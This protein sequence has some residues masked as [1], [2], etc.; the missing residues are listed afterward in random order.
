MQT[1]SIFISSGQASLS[2]ALWEPYKNNY[3]HIYGFSCL[4]AEI[5]PKVNII[6]SESASWGVKLKLLSYHVDFLYTTMLRM[7]VE[8]LWRHEKVTW[9]TESLESEV[10]KA[11]DK[12]VHCWSVLL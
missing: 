2:A 1:V 11:A 9:S 4:K 8:Y 3:F 5:R 7:S 6:K 12:Y 10:L